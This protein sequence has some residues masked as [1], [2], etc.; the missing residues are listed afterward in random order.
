MGGVLIIFSMDHTQIHPIGGH[1][2]LA[3]C[4][5][6]SCFKIVTIENSVQDSNDSIFKRIQKIA[7]FNYRILVD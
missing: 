6:I 2:F 1:P 4:H 3:S 5:I 7:R